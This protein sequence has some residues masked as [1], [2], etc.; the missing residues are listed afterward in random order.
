MK[1]LSTFGTRRYTKK[2]VL[3]NRSS[4]K[5]M[6][7]GKDVTGRF[8]ALRCFDNKEEAVIFLNEYRKPR[9][10][11]NKIPTGKQNHDYKS[12]TFINEMF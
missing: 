10:K 2:E 3:Y 11:S 7:I 8:V 1:K 4:K 5:Y 6:A 12:E 9:K